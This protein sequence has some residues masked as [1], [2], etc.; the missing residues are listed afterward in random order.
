[1]HSGGGE[2]ERAAVVLLDRRSGG[3]PLFSVLVAVY[4]VSHYIG[5]T[6]SE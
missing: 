3:K 2:L 6:L 4:N 5:A 1:M